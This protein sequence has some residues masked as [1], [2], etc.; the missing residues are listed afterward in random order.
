MFYSIFF[1]FAVI[2]SLKLAENIGTLRM[3]V[4]D[5]LWL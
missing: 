2:L 3:T 4:D 1:A 5:S